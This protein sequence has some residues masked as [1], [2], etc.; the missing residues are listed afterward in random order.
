MGTTDGS[1]ALKVVPVPVYQQ[2]NKFAVL[3]DGIF[4]FEIARF[5]DEQQAKDYIAEAMKPKPREVKSLTQDCQDTEWI[6]T[7]ANNHYRYRHNGYCWQWRPEGG[8]LWKDHTEVNPSCPF[9]PYVEV[10]KREPRVVDI[11]GQADK[12]VEWIRNGTGSRFRYSKLKW[13]WQFRVNGED[14]WTSYDGGNG[15]GPFTEVIE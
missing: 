4:P 13:F 6:Y 10:L 1:L 12:A 2:V 5:D 3:F 14:E 15:L 7:A 11:L 9:Y 8:T